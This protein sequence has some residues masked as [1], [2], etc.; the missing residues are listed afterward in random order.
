MD[1]T[2]SNPNSVNPIKPVLSGGGASALLLGK[3]LFINVPSLENTFFSN[4]KHFC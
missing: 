4:N 1:S 2:S 3:T